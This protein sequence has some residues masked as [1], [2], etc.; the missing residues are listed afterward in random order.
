[1]KRHFIFLWIAFFSF[2]LAGCDETTDMIGSSVTNR[3]DLLNVSVDTFNVQSNTV[4]FDSVL[5]RNIIGYLGTV[6]D[7]ETGNTITGNFM[8]QFNLLNGF[9]LPSIDSIA[10]DNNG[11]VIADSCEIRLYYENYY[12]D[13]LAQMKLKAFELERPV[14]E[15]LKIYSNFNPKNN[16]VREN[17]LQQT[18]TYTL[19]DFT[20]GDSLRADSKYQPNIRI[21]LNK[22]YV[23]KDGIQYNNYGSYILRQYYKNPNNFK[24]T[25]NFLHN[26]VPGFFF[27]MEEGIG[28]MAY[29]NSAQLNFFFRYITNDTVKNLSTSFTSTEEVL[30]TTT[31][32]NNNERLKKIAADESCT[33]IKTPVG[34]YTEITIPVEEIINTHTTDTL[35]SVKLSLPCLTKSNLSSTYKFPKPSYLLLIPKDSV[36]SFF[37][38]NKIPDNK[39][40]FIASYNSKQNAYTFSNFSGIIN[41]MI[42]NKNVANKNWNKIAVIPVSVT[43]VTKQN[44]NSTIQTITKVAHDMSISSAQL[45]GGAMNPNALKLSVIYSKFQK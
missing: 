16:Y 19:A 3:T 14:E 42:A 22:P 33:Y 15:G 25:Y 17:G 1:M 39:T 35:N 21:K 24:T 45:V 41:A 11:D 12:G 4:L 23:D 34:L 8:A 43:L 31:F 37:E 5:A 28:S 29:I 44:G 7:P 26:V 40:S 20:E 10:K 27:E 38:Q 30:Q 13:S 6:K 36:C 18:R 32:S 9:Y 2:L